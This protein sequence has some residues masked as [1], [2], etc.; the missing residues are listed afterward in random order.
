L[1]YPANGAAPSSNFREVWLE[2]PDGKSLLALIN[3]DVGWLM[4]L[5]E[6]GDPGFSSRNP[7]YDGFED[8]MVEYYLNN[9]QRDLY[10][11]AWAYPTDVIE[12]G[13]EYFRQHNAPPPFI[14]WYND[15]DDGTTISGAG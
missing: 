5:R 2:S 8:E 15:S 12:R 13:L 7:N 9:G 4:Y 1:H 3:G 14:E 10:P 6:A 11:R